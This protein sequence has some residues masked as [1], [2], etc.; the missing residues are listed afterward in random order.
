[1]IQIYVPSLQTLHV[2]SRQL[3]AVDS[4]SCRW[5]QCW[6]VTCWLQH[7]LLL[8]LSCA[9][10]MIEFSWS[11]LGRRSHLAGPDPDTDGQSSG[12]DPRGPRRS[13]SITPAMHSE[14]LICSVIT[15]MGCDT[16]DPH[17]SSPTQQHLQAFPQPPRA[18][19]GLQGPVSQARWPGRGH[20]AACACAPPA[21]PAAVRHARAPHL[22]PAMP[23]RAFRCE[24]APFRCLFIFHL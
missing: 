11:C 10:T 20:A 9:P 21:R 19:G 15:D 18:S 5:D 4:C 3:L 22:Q 16:R 23:P 7:F 12:S 24:K 8:L 17:R 6:L 1:M 2:T 14:S 13:N